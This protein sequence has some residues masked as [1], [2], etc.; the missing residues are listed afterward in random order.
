MY[1]GYWENVP[2]KYSAAWREIFSKNVEGTNLSECCPICH[3][4]SL[5][6]YYQVEKIVEDKKHMSIGAEWQW[7]SYCRHYEHTQVI[8]PD[9]WQPDFVIDGDKLTVI[10]EILD[11]AYRDIEKIN[12]WNSVPKAFVSLWNEIFDQNRNESRINEN[13]PICNCRML[14]QY[15]TLAI[16]NPIK[17]KKQFYKG[18]GARWEWCA[19][20]FHYKF[21]NLSFVPN[22]W[23]NELE[24]ETWRL[25][26]VPEPINEYINNND[27]Q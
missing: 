10:P 22:D 21:D 23:Q 15:Y 19:N 7:C 14:R 25:M 12:R 13:C 1:N 24:I 6:R 9:W 3:K 18:Q 11:V 16:S 26:S 2:D 4:R 27:N 5:H 20:C 8:V 17:Y